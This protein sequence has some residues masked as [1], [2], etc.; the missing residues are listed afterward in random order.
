MPR[1]KT[2]LRPMDMAWQAFQ[3]GAAIYEGYDIE[4][5]NK[6]FKAWWARHP[7]ALPDGELKKE[8]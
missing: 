1:K 8:P 4:H 3:A 2:L 5:L 6:Q 7:Q